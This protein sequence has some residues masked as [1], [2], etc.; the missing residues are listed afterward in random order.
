MQST[1]VLALQEEAAEYFMVDVFSDT[2]LCAQ[3][4]KRVT[5]NVGLRAI[6][7]AYRK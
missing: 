6:E 3:H 7:F 1:A 4:G 2:S 5:I